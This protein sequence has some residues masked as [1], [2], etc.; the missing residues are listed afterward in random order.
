M[1]AAIALSLV[2]EMELVLTK[3]HSAYR[4]NKIIIPGQIFF[5]FPHGKYHNN[6]FS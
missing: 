4:E 3:D 1:A 2:F 5:F 6:A